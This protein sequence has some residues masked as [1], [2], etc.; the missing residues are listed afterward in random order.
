MSPRFRPCRPAGF[1]VSFWQGVS[2]VLLPLP[3]PFAWLYGDFVRSFFR[4]SGQKQLHFAGKAKNPRRIEKMSCPRFV[5]C[6][7]LIHTP[8]DAFLLPAVPFVWVRKIKTPRLWVA[9]RRGFVRATMLCPSVSCSVCLICC[10]LSS[11]APAASLS[12]V[13]ICW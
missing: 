4:G 6:R 2:G 8:G 3:A 1:C 12:S 9:P 5:P 13:C 10:W 7:F 11:F